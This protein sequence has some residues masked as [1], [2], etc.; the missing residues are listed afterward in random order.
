MK[1]HSNN[2]HPEEKERCV[3]E[4]HF[5]RVIPCPA[6]FLRR[7]CP[8]LHQ[9]HDRAELP[10]LLSPKGARG[11]KATPQISWGRAAF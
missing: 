7:A 9:P 1:R 8:Y 2:T 4:D 6:A 10:V 5:P 3:M 11:Q